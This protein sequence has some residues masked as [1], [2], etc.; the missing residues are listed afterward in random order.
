M[1]EERNFLSRW[2]RRKLE[3]TRPAEKPAEQPVQKAPEQRPEQRPELPP[4][5]SLTFDSD[6]SAYLKSNVEESVKRAALKKLLH[7]PRFN[8]MDGLDTYIDDYTK[9]DPIPEEMLKTLEHA[10]S[11]FLGLE[12][13]KAPTQETP[14]EAVQA[15][16]ED[17]DTPSGDP[18]QDA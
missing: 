17:K 10:R 11:T 4:V 14:A 5:E 2:S 16:Q 13:P 12:T 6:F 15:E 8:V 1:S 18:R 9:N 7:D 3:A